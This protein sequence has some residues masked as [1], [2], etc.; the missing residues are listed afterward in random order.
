MKPSHPVEALA[1]RG[2]ISPGAVQ[3]FPV[4]AVLGW[5]LVLLAIN[6]IG[7]VGGG[8]DDYP[9][10][11]AAR[12]FARHGVCLP[13]DHWARRYPIVLPEAAS[14]YLFGENA[15]S[16]AI[17][18]LLYTLAGVGLF[19]TIVQ[20]RFGAPAALIAGAVFAATPVVVLRILEIG[21]D[22]PEFV[23]VLLAV[24][25]LDRPECGM[26]RAIGSGMM[27]GMAIQCRPTALVLLPVFLL[28]LAWAGQ[29]RDIGPFLAGVLLPNLA[30][31]AVYWAG[32]GDPLT[33]WKLSLAHAHIPSS[34]LSG[35][36]DTSRSPLF[37]PDFI[38]GW[39]RTM[40]IHIHWSIDGL[41]NLFAD[42]EIALT[43]LAAMA[44]CVV[45]RPGNRALLPLAGV[46]A[47]WFA[48]LTYGLA[49]DPKPRMFL[50]V[51]AVASIAL[52]VAA[53]AHWRRSRAL[54][55]IALTLVAAKGL[56]TAWE[57][58]GI[59][60]PK[61]LA[62]QWAAQQGGD[63]TVDPT[64]ASFLTLEPAVRTLPPAAAAPD[65]RHMLLFGQTGCAQA[66][67]ARGFA[68]W[69]VSRAASFHTIEPPF[70]MAL[71]NRHIVL[72]PRV[73]PVVCI[74]TRPGPT[75]G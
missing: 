34:E 7:Y 27:L 53:T 37:N 38:G 32:T 45:G 42:P 50:I 4:I 23:F 28:R 21:I 72:S 57:R 8:G 17:A 12:C 73:V 2:R 43:L 39:R 67:R 55:A 22:L 6:P 13:Y 26:A 74:L 59:A 9:Y 11:S 40:G 15:V 19:T 63:L 36:V 66:A 49:V 70:V 35:Q 5:L 33:P 54:I 65:R 1:R 25:V 44:M 61:A 29:A 14:L 58:T 69:R 30:E 60:G 46:A 71:R 18:P 75:R 16:V 41:L 3:M 68:G 48:G 64:T 52:G 62:A 10:L 24:F 31:A 20:R 56:I 51:A 47:F